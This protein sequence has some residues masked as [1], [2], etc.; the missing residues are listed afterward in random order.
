MKKFLYKT[1]KP[2]V[3]NRYVCLKQKQENREYAVR[4]AFEILQNLGKYK[5]IFS[6]EEYNCCKM[7][8]IPYCKENVD[9]CYHIA[10]DPKYETHKEE[11]IKRIISQIPLNEPTYNKKQVD[12]YLN[13]LNHNKGL[14]D[15]PSYLSFK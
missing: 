5:T 7:L 12:S 9:V 3:Y 1:F 13:C 2:G 8:G 10:Y 11:F 14:E 6:W 15:P 4:A